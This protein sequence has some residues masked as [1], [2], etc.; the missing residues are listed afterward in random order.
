MNL[1]RLHVFNTAP[2]DHT[3]NIKKIFKSISLGRASNEG[4]RDFSSTDTLSGTGF[5]FGSGSDLLLD[6]PM[7]N[8]YY[9]IKLYKMS[10]MLQKNTFVCNTEML[11]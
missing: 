1:K 8:A 3:F 9:Y 5:G 11:V 10:K 4:E 2:M 6:S 7:T